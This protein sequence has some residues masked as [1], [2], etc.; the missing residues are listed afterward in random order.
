MISSTC[1]LRLYRFIGSAHPD[2]FRQAPPSFAILDISRFWRERLITD[3]ETLNFKDIA[4]F[5]CRHHVSFRRQ[6]LITDGVIYNFKG[7]ACRFCGFN[8][9]L[10]TLL[11]AVL[12]RFLLLVR[13]CMVLFSANLV[14]MVQYPTRWICNG[15]YRLWCRHLA[16]TNGGGIPLIFVYGLL[17]IHL[18]TRQCSIQFRISDYGWCD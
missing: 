7:N 17:H 2:L 4:V 11:H 14:H 10:C 1:N 13:R 12:S 3:G 8:S 15:R 6:S 5:R 16:G 9:I 18:L